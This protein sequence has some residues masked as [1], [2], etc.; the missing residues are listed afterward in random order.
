MTKQIYVFMDTSSLPRNPAYIGLGFESLCQLVQSGMAKIYLSSIVEREWQ[1]QLQADW[2]ELV[3]RS[4]NS[5]KKLLKHPWTSSIE[6]RSSLVQA[7]K[8]LA[9]TRFHIELI[10]HSNYE[11]IVEKLAPEILP[12]E[13]KHSEEVFD[14]Y[15]KRRLPFK[16]PKSR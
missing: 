12:I 16:S 4:Q 5:L 6:S 3:S 9:L 15:F 13:D 7:L 8:S 10:S 1:S 2:I 14:R 11:K